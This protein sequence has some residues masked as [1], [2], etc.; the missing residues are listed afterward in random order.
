M[1]ESNEIEMVGLLVQVP[2]ESRDKFKQYCR[3]QHV[4]MNKA[5]FILM[6]QVSN[7]HGYKLRRAFLKESKQ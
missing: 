7:G 2:K 5:F 4:S 6:E 1:M 3:S